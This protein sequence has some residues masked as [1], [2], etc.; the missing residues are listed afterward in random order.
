M[1]SSRNDVPPCL[2]TNHSVCVFIAFRTD[3]NVITKTIVR[4]SDTFDCTTINTT[5]NKPEFR[6]ISFSS[7]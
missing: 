4:R 6:V 5:D 2:R 7:P 3:L 1:Q